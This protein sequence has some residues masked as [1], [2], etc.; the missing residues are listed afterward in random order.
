MGNTHPRTNHWLARDGEQ[1]LECVVKE[2]P[3]VVHGLVHVAD[4]FPDDLERKTYIFYHFA[5]E[6]GGINIGPENANDSPQEG[7]PL[8]PMLRRD[9]YNHMCVGCFVKHYPD[10]FKSVSDSLQGIATFV[11]PDKTLH[12]VSYRNGETGMQ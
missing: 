1:V 10:V 3:A 7:T 5:Q 2:C 6:E 12:P 9:G 11:N 4:V 8:I